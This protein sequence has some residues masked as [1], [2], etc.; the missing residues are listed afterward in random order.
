MTSKPS[1]LL[2]RDRA[3]NNPLFIILAILAFLACLSLL[4]FKTAHTS[5]GQWQTDLQQTATVQIK[6]SSD[7]NSDHITAAQN[8]LMASPDILAADILSQEASRELLKPWLG[9]V[10]LPADLPL[11]ILINIDIQT[12][13]ALNIKALKAQLAEAG[14]DADIDDHS[15]WT[16]ALNTKVRA[17][18]LLALL[19]SVLITIAILAACLSAVRAGISGQSKL[20]D[21]LH[22]V[23]ADPRYTARIFS[24]KFAWTSFKAGV[25]GSAGAFCL[26]FL[27]GL[28]IGSARNDSLLPN[29]TIGTSDLMLAAFIPLF[30]SLISGLITWYTVIKSLHDEVYS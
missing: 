9:D 25:I 4:A 28:M 26:L 20:M 6:Q 21:I 15:Q 8:I 22:H 5:M 16:K 12:G 14:I 17:F 23:G 7:F 30:M 2:P 11:P 10:A 13:R 29:F 18:Q 1:P 19:A 3:R 24:T 27:M